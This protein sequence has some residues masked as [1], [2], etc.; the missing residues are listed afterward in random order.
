MHLFCHPSAVALTA[1]H[2]RSDAGGVAE[3]EDDDDDARLHAAGYDRESNS[4]KSPPRLSFKLALCPAN[5]NRGEPRSFGRQKCV[6][7]QRKRERQRL[8]PAGYFGLALPLRCGVPSA[9]ESMPALQAATRQTS[10]ARGPVD[11]ESQ[12]SNCHHFQH[13]TCVCIPFI[14]LPFPVVSGRGGG[15][16]A[17]A[18]LLNG[19]CA[20]ARSALATR[21]AVCVPCL[22]S[23]LPSL[24]PPTDCRP[25][26]S[27]RFPTGFHCERSPQSLM[28]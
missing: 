9:G 11:Y 21:S 17:R 5:A 15:G 26:F 13:K 19:A 14:R 12:Y 22:P 16:G 10:R 1:A 23:F 27:L 4:A 2:A 3:D 8:V 28:T 24:P 20:L 7:R 25:R 18:G 6:E